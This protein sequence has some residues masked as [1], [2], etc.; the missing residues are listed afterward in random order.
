MEYGKIYNKQQ[1]LDV[2]AVLD[3]RL[4]YNVLEKLA[5]YFGA[6]EIF[7]RFIVGLLV[8]NEHELPINCTIV[9]ELTNDRWPSYE[10]VGI[11]LAE[12]FNLDYCNYSCRINRVLLAG[13]V[14]EFLNIVTPRNEMLWELSND[15]KRAND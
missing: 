15:G 4:D 12:R 7:H 11:Q 13:V 2:L 8:A 10:F 14:D 9:D 6:V 5:T 1:C 3:E